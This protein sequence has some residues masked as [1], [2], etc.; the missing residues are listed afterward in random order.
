MVNDFYLTN[1]DYFPTGHGK[2][3]EI[4]QELKNM[5]SETVKDSFITHFNSVF[6]YIYIKLT[7]K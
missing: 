1:C 4:T 2:G 6:M 5:P 3:R 7:L